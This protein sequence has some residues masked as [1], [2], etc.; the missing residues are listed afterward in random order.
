MKESDLTFI[1]FA[2]QREPN[3]EI[4]P[5]GFSTLTTHHQE[6]PRI[7]SNSEDEIDKFYESIHKNERFP[8]VSNVAQCLYFLNKKIK[9]LLRNHLK[10]LFR[11]SLKRH[12]LRFQMKEIK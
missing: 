12:W 1:E 7:I 9:I 4:L 10:Y 3:S 8:E 6:L 5:K 11:T 2:K